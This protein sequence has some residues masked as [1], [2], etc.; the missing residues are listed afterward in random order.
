MLLLFL[1][2]WVGKQM[3]EKQTRKAK[4]EHIFLQKNRRAISPC[5]RNIVL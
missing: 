3:F 2:N 4:G 5:F 1:D